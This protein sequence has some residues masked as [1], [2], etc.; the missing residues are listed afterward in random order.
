MSF[1]VR[2]IK[3]FFPKQFD[4][5]A[6]APSVGASGGILIIW[7]SS[8]F[9]GQLVQIQCFN[10]VVSFRSVHNSEKWTLVSVYGPCEGQ[11]RD[12]FVSW[13][14][15]LSIPSDENWMLLGDFNFIC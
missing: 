2:E 15:C 4:T 8:V 11:P 1:D 9:E 7:N 5:F 14:Y 13:L 12:D 6:F 10:V 3:S